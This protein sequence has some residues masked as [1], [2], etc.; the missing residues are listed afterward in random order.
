MAWLELHHVEPHGRGGAPTADNLRI[1][2]RVHNDYQAELD[3][4]REHMQRARSSPPQPAAIPTTLISDAFTALCQLGFKPSQ[5]R[6]ALTSATADLA[7]SC[8]LEDL[9]R[10]SLQCVA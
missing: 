10:R 1:Y 4:G 7:A 5:T 9:L 6:N 3:Y 2:C 8:S